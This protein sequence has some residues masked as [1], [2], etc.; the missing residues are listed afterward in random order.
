MSAPSNETL[1]AE[2]SKTLQQAGGLI[3]S[4]NDVISKLAKINQILLENTEKDTKKK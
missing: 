2:F 3:I 4:L 1:A